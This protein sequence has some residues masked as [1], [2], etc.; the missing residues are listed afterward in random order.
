MYASEP[1][2]RTHGTSKTM[3]PAAAAD[4]AEAWPIRGFNTPATP[5]AANP[6]SDACSPWH[7]YTTPPPPAPPTT[8]AGLASARPRLCRMTIS[9]P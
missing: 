5:P 7:Q 6:A 2:T 9:Q 3:P 8:D 4:Q 1:V